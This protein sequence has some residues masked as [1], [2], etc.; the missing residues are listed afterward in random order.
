MD[1]EPSLAGGPIPGAPPSLPVPKNLTPAPDG[2]GR[3]DEAQFIAMMRTG[4]PSRD[5][6]RVYVEVE[7]SY[8]A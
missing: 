7:L 4:R 1:R 8:E 2:L 6:A 3:D 5:G